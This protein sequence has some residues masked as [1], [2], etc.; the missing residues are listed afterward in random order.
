[1]T[2]RA[3]AKYRDSS[4]RTSSGSR[5]SDSVVNPTRSPNRTDVTRRSATRGGA[6]FCWG[7]EAAMTTGGDV[8]HSAQNFPVTA[9][10]QLTQEVACGIPHSGQ[11]FAVSAVLLPH[12][13]QDGTGYPLSPEP[14]DRRSVGPRRRGRRVLAEAARDYRRNFDSGN[15]DKRGY[16]RPAFRNRGEIKYGAANSGPARVRFARRRDPG[17]RNRH[18]HP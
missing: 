16:S 4:S 9:A 18:L 3:A 8:P 1:M 14:A 5:D 17:H 7:T 11:N 6:L 13:E 10:P 2:V 12:D 15:G